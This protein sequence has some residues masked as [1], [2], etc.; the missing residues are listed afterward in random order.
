MFN[1]LVFNGFPPL[2]IA[3]CLHSSALSALVVLVVIIALVLPT[4]Y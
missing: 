2:R 4:R 1:L 3:S